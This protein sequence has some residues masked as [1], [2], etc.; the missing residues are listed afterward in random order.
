MYLSSDFFQ[1]EF[2]WFFFLFINHTFWFLW[3]PCD[4]LIEHWTFELNNA[5]TLEIR[6]SPY[7]RIGWGFLAF[8]LFY[9]FIIAVCC[10]CQGSTWPINVMSAQVFSEPFPGHPRSC[11]NFPRICSCFWTA[12]FLMSGS[13]KGKKRKMKAKKGVSPLNPLELTSA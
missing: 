7:P 13:Q 1:R 3:M 5:V 11:S 12:Y 10:L 2:H 9:F 8:I 6:F 4:F